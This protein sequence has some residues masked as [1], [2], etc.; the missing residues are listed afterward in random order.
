ML[1]AA[2]VVSVLAF[3]FMAARVPGLLSG[4]IGFDLPPCEST[5]SLILAE[6]PMRGD[7][8]AELQIALR[9]VGLYQGPID[10]IL[11]EATASAV[12]AVR[13]G[14]GLDPTPRADADF[15]RAL[16]AEWWSRNGDRAE[17]VPAAVAPPPE[18]EV[19]LVIDIEK[20]Q[21]TVYA[22]GH[23]YKTFPVAVGKPSTPS[24]P[25]QWKVRNK[26]VNVGP[27]FGTRWMGLNIPWG[28]YGVH[29]TNNP[30]SIGSSASGG[31]IRMFNHNVEELYEWVP[32]G[33]RVQIVSPHWPANVPP[34][35][36]KGSIGL[37]VVFLQWQL[38]RLGFPS[39]AADGRLGETTVEA[40][41]DLEAFY[42]LT[43]DGIADTDVLCLL[44]LD[45]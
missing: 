41:A 9:Q 38:E 19:M 32:V 12:S 6:P 22:D 15:W 34:L 30:G 44:D 43:V 18:G 25:G 31:C 29:G 27:P 36:P 5:R 23:P 1:L 28:I 26:G 17:V 42:G 3:S 14:H 4:A 35:L 16:A 10:G 13:A 39:G 37:S 7:D 11:G 21:L 20:R 8:V 40:I 24:Q 45:R 2:G 33:T